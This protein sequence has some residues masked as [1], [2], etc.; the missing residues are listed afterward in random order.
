VPEWVTDR[1]G[2]YYLYFAHHKGTSIRLAYADYMAGPWVVH[3]K[4]VLKLEQS[5]FVPEDLDPTSRSDWVNGPDYLYAHVASPDVHVDHQ[6]KQIL[7]FFHGLLPD[8]DRKMGDYFRR[9]CLCLGH[10]T[11]VHFSG[12]SV[13]IL[14]IFGAT[15]G[16]LKL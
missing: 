14:R 2:K 12:A 9:N 1:L 3:P 8:G 4:P 6:E 13:G 5:L 7:M 10:H 15:W 16:C 11:C